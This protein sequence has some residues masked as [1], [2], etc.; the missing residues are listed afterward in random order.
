[1][2]LRTQVVSVVFQFTTAGTVTSNLQEAFAR[3]PTSII[4]LVSCANSVNDS[5]ELRCQAAKAI[6]ALGQ[7]DWRGGGG[8]F[9]GNSGGS[10]VK[11]VSLSNLKSNY[12]AVVASLQA[13]VPRL[14]SLYINI[15]LVEGDSRSNLND[16]YHGMISTMGSCKPDGE[17]EGLLVC[18][19]NAISAILNNANLYP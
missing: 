2:P 4:H 15:L 16:F 13:A 5:V 17:N 12:N 10:F 7:M 6:H 1:V 8:S 19:C 18:I 14:V 11:S 3:H 9:I